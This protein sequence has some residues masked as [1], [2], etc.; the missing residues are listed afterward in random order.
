MNKHT[1]QF[2]EM[3][4]R[5]QAGEISRDQAALE[6][7]VNRNTLNVWILRAG[8]KGKVPRKPLTAEAAEVMKENLGSGLLSGEASE[9]LDNAIARVLAGGVSALAAAQ[10]DPRVS[11][12]TLA[13][14]VRAARLAAGQPVQSRRSP[15]RPQP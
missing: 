14:R 8:L 10:E 1:P 7:G 2:N 6:Y 3:M 11:P 5:L 13:K 12:S 4:S 9:A 15:Q